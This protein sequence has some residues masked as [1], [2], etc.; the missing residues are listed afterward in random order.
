MKGLAKGIAHVAKTIN[1]KVAM[2]AMLC[3]TAINITHYIVTGDNGVTT[4]LI[5]TAIGAIAGY[6]PKKD[7]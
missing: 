5:A 7:K 1:T 2:T 3:L 4:I 6:V